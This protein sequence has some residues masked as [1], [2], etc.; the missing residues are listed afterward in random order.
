MF[1]VNLSA[2]SL[3]CTLNLQ[4]VFTPRDAQSVESDIQDE[5]GM[6]EFIIKMHC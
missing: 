6:V 1:E 5:I 4:W 2:R 3:D